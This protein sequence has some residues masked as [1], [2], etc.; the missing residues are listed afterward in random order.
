[1]KNLL[2]KL[3]LLILIVLISGC[4]NFPLLEKDNNHKQKIEFF[5]IPPEGAYGAFYAA[6]GYGKFNFSQFD[7]TLISKIEIEHEPNNFSQVWFGNEEPVDYCKINGVTY[8]ERNYTGNR[9]SYSLDENF[10]LYFDGRPNV[11]E[12]SIN[13]QV[14]YDTLYYNAPLIQITTPQYM[15]AYPKNQDLVV[16]WEPSEDENDIVLIDI[17][18]FPNISMCWQDTSIA[19]SYYYF[20]TEDDGEFVFPTSLLQ[21]FKPYEHKSAIT[22]SRGTYKMGYHGGKTYKFVIY[23][24]HKIEIKLIDNN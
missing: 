7:D 21:T 11:F 9:Y 17:M 8:Q 18:G 13:G 23:C 15:N 6:C 22:L 5:Q 14:F 19:T 24:T 16:R 3:A 12:W 2:T 1:M 4:E 10:P 20:L